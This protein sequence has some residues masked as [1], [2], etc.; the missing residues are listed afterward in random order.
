MEW[1]DTESLLDFVFCE[2]CRVMD[3]KETWRM[4]VEMICRIGAERRT[5]GYDFKIG[6]ESPSISGIAT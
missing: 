6:L 2:N 5:L 3:E 1:R 4:N